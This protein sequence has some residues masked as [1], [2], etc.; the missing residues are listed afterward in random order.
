M[1]NGSNVRS[2]PY[3]SPTNVI[4][5]ITRYRERGLPKPLNKVDI[6]AMGI[7]SSNAARSLQTLKFLDFVNDAGYPTERFEQL[8]RA[9]NGEYKEVL[10]N[11]VREAYSPVFQIVDPG[12]DSLE[13]IQGAFR[14]YDPVSELNR[15]VNL[16]L[17]LCVEAGIASEEMRPKSAPRKQG[18]QQ[19]RRAP[20]RKAEAPNGN[21]TNTA[22]SNEQRDVRPPVDDT[23]PLRDSRSL[24]DD[25]PAEYRLM[26]DLL[27]RKLPKNLQWTATQR[28]RWLGAV[29]ANIDMVVEV[30]EPQEE[31]ANM[32]PEPRSVAQPDD[33]DVPI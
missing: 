29:A 4:Q 8:K 1:T 28:E 11:A 16:F 31:R 7:K 19:G 12:Q 9:T 24:N 26:L 20:E 22:Y 30:V 32:Q 17:G 2:V 23:P 21:G 33:D 14:R 15:M 18:T 5:L 25:T 13:Q 10:A 27:L 3:A 6:E